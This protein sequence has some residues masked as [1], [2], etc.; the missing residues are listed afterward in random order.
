MDASGVTLNHDCVVFDGGEAEGSAAVVLDSAATDFTISNTTVRAENTTSDSFEEAIR[1]NY[2][3]AGAMATKDR[4]ED[5]AECVHQLWTLT[6]SYVIANG[7]ENAD[8]EGTAHT[9]DWWFSKNTITATDDTLLNPSKQTAVIFAESGNGI[10]ENHEQVTDSLLAGGGFM[11][12]FCAHSTGAG[13]SSI[14]IKDNRFASR[15]CTKKEIE[16]YEGRGGFGCAPEGG[17]FEDGE[18]S[19]GYF[20][21]GGFFGVV[22]EGEGLYDRGA[23][24][25]GNFWDDN[26][27]GQEE[28]AR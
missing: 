9:E 11:F 21:R 22:F 26:L 18:G 20:P 6:E 3:D 7:R 10:C 16:N 23:G 25:E 15:K 14:E 17:Y 4:F 5:C 2:S 1:N 28:E 8:E 27:K 13:S 12:Y 24:W 19:G